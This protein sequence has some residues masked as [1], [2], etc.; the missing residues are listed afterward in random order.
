MSLKMPWNGELPVPIYGL[1]A[2]NGT[3]E[4]NSPTPGTRNSILTSPL[5]PGG[6]LRTLSCSDR[7]DAPESKDHRT[8]RRQMPAGR[9]VTD[10]YRYVIPDKRRCPTGYRK[11]HR[12]FHQC[13]RRTQNPEGRSIRDVRD[14]TGEQGYYVV[15]DGLSMPTACGYGPRVCQCAGIADDGKGSY[16]RTFSRSSVQL[17]T[18]CRISIGSPLTLTERVRETLFELSEWSCC[19]KICRKNFRRR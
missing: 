18:S 17:T 9:V 11:P 2:S 16:Y 5:R 10:D 1:A 15:S 4:K 19:Q 8:S 12:P 13:D 14:A 7:G 3:C 6:L